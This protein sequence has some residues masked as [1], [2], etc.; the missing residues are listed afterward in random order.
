MQPDDCQPAC[1][2]LLSCQHPDTGYPRFAPQ[3]FEFSD[4][5]HE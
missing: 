3:T 2:M 5:H 1:R 4:R